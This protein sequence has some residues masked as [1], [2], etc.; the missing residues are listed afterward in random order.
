LDLCEIS[1]AGAEVLN[2]DIELYIAG[3]GGKCAKYCIT[4]SE[5]EAKMLYL[6]S[7]IKFVM[8]S[9]VLLAGSAKW[10]RY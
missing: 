7:L 9:I 3:T 10:N 4:K 5:A 8:L 1:S 6:F 2:S